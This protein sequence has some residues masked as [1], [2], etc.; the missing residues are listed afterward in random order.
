MRE[1]AVA[2]G[3]HHQVAVERGGTAG[4]CLQYNGS[5]K[6]NEEDEGR[7]EETA[8]IAIRVE[9]RSRGR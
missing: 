2:A 1:Q 8:G 6:P 9:A 7:E 4:E 3:G 5:K